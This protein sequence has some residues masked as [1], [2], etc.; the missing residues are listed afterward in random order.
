[1]EWALLIYWCYVNDKFKRFLDYVK[2][3]YDKYVPLKTIQIKNTKPSWF[4]HEVKRVINQRNRS[5]QN[6]RRTPTH[7]NWESYKKLRHLV[8]VVTKKLETSYYQSTLNCNLPVS[9]LWKILYKIG[10][11]KNSNEC[12]ISSDIT[13]DFFLRTT[14]DTIQYNNISS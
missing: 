13:N 4:N 9:Q 5:H 2:Y 11:N 1:M 6:W 10:I 12:S 14:V 8:H 3:L 7:T